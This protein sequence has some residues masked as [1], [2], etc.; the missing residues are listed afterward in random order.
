[1]EDRTIYNTI[2]IRLR[3]FCQRITCHQETDCP[4]RGTPGVLRFTLSSGYRVFTRGPVSFK[5]IGAI[6]LLSDSVT[7]YSPEYKALLPDA[8]LLTQ[9]AVSCI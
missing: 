1:M 3:G 8:L 5:N 7:L 9:F 6:V 4:S 2:T